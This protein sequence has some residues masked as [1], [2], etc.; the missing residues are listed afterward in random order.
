MSSTRVSSH[1][2][3]WTSILCLFL[4][5]HRCHNSLG[6]RGARSVD[7]RR[8]AGCC[9]AR[10]ARRGLLGR[11]RKRRQE[12]ARG[13]V[14]LVHSQHSSC[15]TELAFDYRGRGQQQWPVGYDFVCGIASGADH[16]LRNGQGHQDCGYVGRA[17]GAA[18][19]DHV[20]RGHSGQFPTV[21]ITIISVVCATT[22]KLIYWPRGNREA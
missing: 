5:T 15:A 9:R 13:R 8:G 11:C 3:P 12:Q 7:R 18:G 21:H 2:L 19:R 17:R 14:S 16:H 22:Q 1:H 10:P 4:L 20:F 6:H